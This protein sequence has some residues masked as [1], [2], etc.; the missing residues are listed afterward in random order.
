[1]THTN[2][3]SGH[4][5]TGAEQPRSHHADTGQ[6]PSQRR[7]RRVLSVTGAVV[8]TVVTLAVMLFA[9][10]LVSSHDLHQAV[11]SGA[12]HGIADTSGSGEAASAATARQTGRAGRP[13]RPVV[14]AFVA[15]TTGTI[16]SDLLAPYDIFA[17]SPAFHHLRGRRARRPRPAGGRPGAGA[18]PH[19][20]R[21]RRRPRPDSPTWS[22]CPRSPSPPAAPRLR[23][24]TG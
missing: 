4:P 12:G 6:R 7:L 15:G 9:G 5:A 14:V 17:S 3:S 8:L 1:M 18:D 22:S 20:R 13:R 2:N 24:A 11:P 19:V 21:R 16:A 10:A 23:C